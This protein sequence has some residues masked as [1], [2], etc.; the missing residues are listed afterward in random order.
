MLFIFSKFL[1]YKT[2]SLKEAL[3]SAN[4]TDFSAVSSFANVGSERGSLIIGS[5]SGDGFVSV[6]SNPMFAKE[7]LYNWVTNP[8]GVLNTLYIPHPQDKERV[9]DVIFATTVSHHNP[10]PLSSDDAYVNFPDTYNDALD[11][12]TSIHNCIISQAT[13]LQNRFEPGVAILMNRVVPETRGYRI[14]FRLI[15]PHIVMRPSNYALFLKSIAPILKKGYELDQ[16]TTSHYNLYGSFDPNRPN[17]PSALNFRIIT[18]DKGWRADAEDP[19]VLNNDSMDMLYDTIDELQRN[20]EGAPD[21]E[22][23]FIALYTV[24]RLMVDTECTHCYVYTSEDAS[25]SADSEIVHLGGD[26]LESD[27]A[28]T[29]VAMI[30]AERLGNEIY[31]GPIA[32]ALNTIHQNEQQYATSAASKDSMHPKDIFMSNAGRSVPLIPPHEAAR[33]WETHTRTRRYT[34]ATLM[35]YAEED[36]PVKYKQWFRAYYQAPLISMESAGEIVNIAR[37]IWRRMRNRYFIVKTSQRESYLYHCTGARTTENAA[38]TAIDAYIDRV[39]EAELKAMTAAIA[40]RTGPDRAQYTV[41][42]GIISKIQLSLLKPT[43]KTIINAVIDE[44]NKVSPATL[45]I[46]LNSDVS[47]FGVKNGVIETIRTPIFRTRKMEDYLTMESE[48]YYDPTLTYDCPRVKA[49]RTFFEMYFD[50]DEDNKECSEYMKKLVAGRLRGVNSE[51]LCVFLIGQSNSG[52]S[53]WCN[54]IKLMLGSY[55]DVAPNNL[56]CAKRLGGADDAAPISLEALTRRFT[57]LSEVAEIS[58][59]I[60]KHM[61]GAEIMK[62]RALYSSGVNVMPSTQFVVACNAF[63]NFDDADEAVLRRIV[64]IYCRALFDDHAPD[65]V[66][67]QFRRRHFKIDDA[68][69]AA[70]RAN[71]SALLY[72]MMYHYEDYCKGMREGPCNSA[73]EVRNQFRLTDPRYT[74]VSRHIV[75]KTVDDGMILTEEQLLMAYS[76]FKGQRATKSVASQRMARTDFLRFS[77]PDMLGPPQTI[78]LGGGVIVSGWKQWALTG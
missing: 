55:G 1:D 3:V 10:V 22:R 16:S 43:R 52:K 19:E 56:F 42:L 33:I 7:Y 65:S 74:F 54:N 24:L 57:S 64:I 53:T 8:G 41:I 37:Y 49:M 77:S 9:I 4:I 51:K 2:S 34:L 66:E 46:G 73:A 38:Y 27:H 15:F 21:V 60:F 61:T 13:E 5:H 62:Y 47:L 59:H 23:D 50:P 12:A 58:A 31:L 35:T 30:N 72:L 45:G 26:P 29:L 20:L 75:K 76:A 67:E 25:T 69:G 14:V 11:L 68:S 17:F 36:N 40:S 63:P 28:K 48:M 39:I 6:G 78:D 32:N 44:F 71:S 70:V 18:A